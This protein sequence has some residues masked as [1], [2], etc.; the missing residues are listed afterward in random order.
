MT[1]S[2]T[3]YQFQAYNL[4]LLLSETNILFR[5]TAGK[6]TLT[7]APNKVR[8]FIYITPNSSSNPMF[9]H[10]L[11]SSHRDDSNKLSNIGF[12]EEITQL[13]LIDLFSFFL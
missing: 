10:L 5:D 11:E 13:V 8:I 4:L 2:N 7:R 3:C 12:T 1:V 9:D 6:S